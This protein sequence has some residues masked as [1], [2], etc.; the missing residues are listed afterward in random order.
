MLRH[1]IRVAI[2][3]VPRVDR[4]LAALPRLYRHMREPPRRRRL[5]MHPWQ[6]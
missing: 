2:L 4:L 3:G 5:Q 1:G 6:S